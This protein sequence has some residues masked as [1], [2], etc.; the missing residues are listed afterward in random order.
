MD[1][2]KNNL[3]DIIAKIGWA[4]M[5]D[6]VLVERGNGNA[7]LSE[8]LEILKRF[9]NYISADFENGECQVVKLNGVNVCLVL[10]ARTNSR[11]TFL[12]VNSNSDFGGC[13]LKALNGNKRLNN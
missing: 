1:K 8:S 7:S 3:N 9:A 10:D 12:M 11:D 5:I 6:N 13:L 2:K 4:I